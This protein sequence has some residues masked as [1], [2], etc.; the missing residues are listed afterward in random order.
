MRHPNR[1]VKITRPLT[2]SRL[3][4]REY[5]ELINDRSCQKQ[6]FEDA[7]WTR[8]LIAHVDKEVK[9]VVCNNRHYIIGDE[10]E[11]SLARGFGGRKFRITFFDG[12]V[13][14]TTNLWSQGLIPIPFQHIFHNNASEVINID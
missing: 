11:K 14:H 1:Q 2:I 8:L 6:M 9:Y 7:Y 4:G 13:V 12:T 3:N 10:D 5:Q